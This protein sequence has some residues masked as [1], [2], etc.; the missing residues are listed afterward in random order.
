[1]G[2][3]FT[4]K[5]GSIFPVACSAVPLRIGPTV[6]GTAVIFRAVSP[7]P[8]VERSVR[9]LLASADEK[10]IHAFR[11]ILDAHEGTQVIN[12]AG[13]PAEAVAG[14]Q[15]HH[16]HVA[17]VDYD[18]PDLD[19]VETA[20]LI[21]AGAPGTK[22]LLVVDDHDEDIVLAAIDAGCN[23][24]LPRARAWVELVAAIDAAHHGGAVMS[25]RELQA[26]VSSARRQEP[27]QPGNP[28][29]Q[30]ER[31]VLAAISEGLSNKQ[32]GDRLGL[33]VNT[34]RN[35]VQRILYKLDVH[36]KLE[37]VVVARQGE[38][39]PGARKAEPDADAR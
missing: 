13:T 29:T 23:G 9:V 33:T 14:A 8:A 25:H 2:E 16:P 11:D 39:V 12:V 5:D 36:S 6:E 38:M 19:G 35:H 34:V 4:R 24:V 31:E 20:T 21:R 15:A 32:V 18:L 1:V 37:A 22:V 10:A 28:L 3:A 26:V 17:V 30:R 7:V 27:E